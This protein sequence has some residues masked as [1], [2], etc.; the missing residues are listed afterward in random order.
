MRK[1]ILALALT[2]I[3]STAVMAES[4]LAV[5]NN[6]KKNSKVFKVNKKKKR[7]SNKITRKHRRSGHKYNA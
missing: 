1:L 4:S 5:E 6:N 7:Y 3:M 2:G